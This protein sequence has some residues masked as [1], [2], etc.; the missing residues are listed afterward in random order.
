MI[1]ADWNLDLDHLALTFDKPLVVQPLANVNWLLSLGKD[2]G[3]GTIVPD[4]AMVVAGVPEVVELAFGAPVGGDAFSI[5]YF[6]AP[7]DVVGAPPN[8]ASVAAFVLP[9]A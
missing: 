8:G 7:P 3:G 1:A 9:L 2:G 4:D 5:E 6:A